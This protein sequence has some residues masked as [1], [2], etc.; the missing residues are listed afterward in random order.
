MMATLLTR[1][2]RAAMRVM[3][4]LVWRVRN[5][6]VI[7]A[8]PQ[9]PFIRVY[10]KHASVHVRAVCATEFTITNVEWIGVTPDSALTSALSGLERWPEIHRCVRGCLGPDDVLF[11]H[12]VAK[13]HTLQTVRV[14]ADRS[15]P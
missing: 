12:F 10:Q 14:G 3:P 5:G 1:Y 15:T 13:D 7:G 8:G 11:K 9:G 4:G 6:V 2:R